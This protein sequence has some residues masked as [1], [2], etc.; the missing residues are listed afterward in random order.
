MEQRIAEALLLVLSAKLLNFT[1]HLQVWSLFIGLKFIEWFN[2]KSFLS[3][4]KHIILVI[5]F[6]FGHSSISSTLG[7][8]LNHPS[9]HVLGHPFNQSCFK[10]T[11]RLFYHTPLSLVC[12][13]FFLLI[14]VR[15]LAIILQHLLLFYLLLFSTKTSKLP[16]FIGLFSIRLLWLHGQKS[17]VFTWLL[18]RSSLSTFI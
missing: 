9:S 6:I 18:T 14:F 8:L 11:R 7:Q 15:F 13:T 10:I 2:I 17:P 5:H 4:T 12:G 3:H 1:T 16:C